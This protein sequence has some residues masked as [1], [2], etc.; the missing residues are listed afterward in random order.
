MQLAVSTCR[1]AVAVAVAAIR[2]VWAVPVPV[3]GHI[4]PVNLHGVLAGDPGGAARHYVHAAR[5]S[6][7]GLLDHGPWRSASQPGQEQ[8]RGACPESGTMDPCGCRRSG[9]SVTTEYRQ[10]VCSCCTCGPLPRA[11]GEVPRAVLRLATAP[12]TPLPQASWAGQVLHGCMCTSCAPPAACHPKM[13]H[14][15]C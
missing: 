15:W 6:A 2:V 11:G 12:H 4:H 5:Q 9:G 3:L 7:G 10:A 8:R 13:L 14:A 1:L